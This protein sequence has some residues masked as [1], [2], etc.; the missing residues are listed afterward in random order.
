[1][2]NASTRETS[3]PYQQGH[4]RSAS[5]SSR[6]RSGSAN[7]AR[8]S[9]PL[10][11]GSVGNGGS[12]GGS[13][14]SS[15]R[16]RDRE[17][18]TERARNLEHALFGL[19]LMTGSSRA[20]RTSRTRE[21]EREAREARKAEKEKEKE[22]ERQRS[23][24]EESCDGLLT[25]SRI[26]LKDWANFHDL[27]LGGFLVTQGVYTGIQDFKDKVVRHFMVRYYILILECFLILCHS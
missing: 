2:G 24:R 18:D 17:R 12:G 13:A 22:R 23:L 16:D 9:N 10:L 7:D 14:Y 21:E 25:L 6:Y 5:S 1:M 15:R 26:Q 20:E 8:S 19:G 3:S 11:G 27:R 4:S